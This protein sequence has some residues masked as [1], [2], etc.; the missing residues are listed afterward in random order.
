MNLAR[1]TVV[2]GLALVALALAGCQKAGELVSEFNPNLSAPDQAL[3]AVLDRYLVRG[4][5]RQGP[6]T[7]MLL[8]VLPANMAVRRAW[9]LRRA[10]AYGWSADRQ[11]KELADQAKEFA[12]NI[13][14][15]A[16]VYV[17][18]RKWNDLDRPN[19]T[20]RAFLV[21]AKGQR[22]PPKDVRRISQRTAIN[23]AIHPFWDPW[24]QLYLAKFSWIG[25][26]GQPFLAPGEKTA[27][28]LV[29]GPPGR[30]EL[31]L[32]VR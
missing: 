18:E 4:A 26:D 32:R 10:Q 9:T 25:Q 14:V 12:A 15:A 30:V 23:E 2:I 6:A 27:T 21:N 7:E 19:S 13:V 17:P 11:H 31:K 5:I 29:T 3:Q 28:L 1:K 22:Q 20:W 16:S 8:T 24:S